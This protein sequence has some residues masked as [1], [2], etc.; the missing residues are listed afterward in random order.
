MQDHVSKTDEPARDKAVSSCVQDMVKRGQVDLE[1]AYDLLAYR[2]AAM[3]KKDVAEG[4]LGW[5]SSL[6][7]AVRAQDRLE[8]EQQRFRPE[9]K[10]SGGK[11]QKCGSK[12]TYLTTEVTRS[13]DE[14][15]SIFLVCI[16]QGCGHKQRKG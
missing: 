16:N 4:M 9:V 7:E 2:D 6:F 3:L 12:N 15:M 10:K 5:N 14:P 8:I 11:C 13:L 1:T